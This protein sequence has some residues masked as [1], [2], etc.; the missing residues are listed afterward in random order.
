M[1]FVFFEEIS[2]RIFLLYCYV[3][4][5]FLLLFFLNVT[6]NLSFSLMFLLF[7]T[8]QQPQSFSS[9]VLQQITI[10]AVPYTS[11]FEYE[12]LNVTQVKLYLCDKY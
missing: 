8:Q 1:S 11:S 5:F 10:I 9:Q 4:S 2:H 7:G 12:I 6:D 3:Y